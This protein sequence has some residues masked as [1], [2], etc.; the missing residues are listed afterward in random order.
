M[1]VIAKELATSKEVKFSVP[2]KAD[3]SN[4]NEIDDRQKVLVPFDNTNRRDK[5]TEK[6]DAT[7]AKRRLES[8]CDAIQEKCTETYKWLHANHDL[9]ETE[10]YEQRYDELERICSSGNKKMKGNI[11]IELDD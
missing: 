11:E 7:A 1:S 3:L 4:A 8:Y 5:D 6:R 10:Q 9:V 2:S